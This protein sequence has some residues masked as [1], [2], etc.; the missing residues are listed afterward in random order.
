[1]AFLLLRIGFLQNLM[2][3]LVDV[4]NPLNEFGGFSSLRLTWEESVCV[5]VRGSA[6]SMGHKGWNLSPT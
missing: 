4:L 5:V 1:M 6:T 3:L 2:D